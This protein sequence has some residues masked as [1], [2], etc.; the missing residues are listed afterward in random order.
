[1][2]DYRDAANPAIRHEAHAV[3]RR[4]R[5]PITASDDLEPV[6]RT[7]YAPASYSPLPA[8]DEL[9]AELGTQKKITGD[10]RVM[11]VSMSEVEQRMQTQ[12]AML[13]R[14]SA[15]LLKVREQLETERGRI[16]SA[17]NPDISYAG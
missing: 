17:T 9:A 2:R 12:Y 13:V 6:R 10:L 15:E 14:Q 16:R 4:T 3:Y 11:Q 8:S 1:M 5:V 7:V